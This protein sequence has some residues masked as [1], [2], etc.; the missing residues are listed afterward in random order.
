MWEI[1]KAPLE[2]ATVLGNGLMEHPMK[3]SGK[4]IMQVGKES[5]NM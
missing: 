3:A 4:T 2:M 1:G 5:L